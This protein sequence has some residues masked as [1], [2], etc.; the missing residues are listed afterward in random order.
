[1]DQLTLSL[2]NQVFNLDGMYFIVQ[3]KKDSTNGRN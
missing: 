1:M 3:I 2:I